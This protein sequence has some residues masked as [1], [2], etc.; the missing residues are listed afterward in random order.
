MV[1]ACFSSNSM[2]VAP[3][4]FT[5]GEVVMILVWKF[6]DSVTNACMMH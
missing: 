1:K 6:S 3:L 4:S 2:C 5:F